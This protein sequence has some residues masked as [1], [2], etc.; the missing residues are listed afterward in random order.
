ML[1]ESPR[2]LCCIDPVCLPAVNSVALGVLVVISLGTAGRLLPLYE[3]HETPPGL[4][5]S[6]DL[7]LPLVTASCVQSGHW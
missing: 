6:L 2:V 1:A 5:R 7:R 4:R 3:Q